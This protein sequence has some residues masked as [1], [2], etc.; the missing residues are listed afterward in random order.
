MEVGTADAAALDGN[1]NLTGAGI[2]GIA[3][4]NAQIAGLMNDDGF[5]GDS[6]QVFSAVGTLT[7]SAD[8]S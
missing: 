4:L 5:H 8:R 6:H 1:G 7:Q 3:L 2:P